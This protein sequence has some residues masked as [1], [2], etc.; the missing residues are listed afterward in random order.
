MGRWGLHQRTLPAFYFKPKTEQ[1]CLSPPPARDFEEIRGNEP[2]CLCQKT[3][4]QSGSD[5]PMEFC[6]WPPH[7]SAHCQMPQGRRKGMCHKAQKDKKIEVERIERWGSVY[8]RFPIPCVEVLGLERRQ[9]S[10]GNKMVRCPV[11]EQTNP[12]PEASQGPLIAIIPNCKHPFGEKNI[13]R[14]MSE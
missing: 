12:M 9:Q 2:G 14:Y 1:D 6:N 8:R 4:F 13:F 10:P 3:H 5:L 7:T 11:G